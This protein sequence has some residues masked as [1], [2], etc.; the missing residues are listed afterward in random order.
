LPG[1][2]PVR[3]LSTSCGTVGG[4]IRAGQGSMLPGGFRCEATERVRCK[5]TRLAPLGREDQAV[6]SQRLAGLGRGL[7]PHDPARVHARE[8][9]G[10]A[11][12]DGRSRDG[13]D[14][15]LL[16]KEDLLHRRV[17]YRVVKVE[18]VH[19]PAPKDAP[20]RVT[21]PRGEPRRRVTRIACARW[22]NTS[23]SRSVDTPFGNARSVGALD[24]ARAVRGAYGEKAGRRGGHVSS[25]SRAICSMN[26]YM[27]G[28]LR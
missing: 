7:R 20:A 25:Q 9:R 24:R 21:Q 22:F 10:D 26:L 3:D 13:D 18:A 4:R 6:L 11:D 16:Y 5:A 19:E 12:V 2:A 14:G 17:R 27:V 15:A 8:T 1:L 28:C 23:S